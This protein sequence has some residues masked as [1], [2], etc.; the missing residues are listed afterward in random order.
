M[1]IC[2][3]KAIPVGKKVFI[4]GESILESI[5]K[6]KKRYFIIPNSTRIVLNEAYLVDAYKLNAEV[7]EVRK[8]TISRYTG[9]KENAFGSKGREIYEGDIIEGKY[10]CDWFVGVVESAK[11]VDDFSIPELI[12]YLFISN[13]N[14]A[15]TI[16]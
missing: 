8:D 14:K 12:P 13:D 4:Y 9:F 16:P 10:R 6:G 1:K 2:K 7:V 15:K 5:Y 3:Y 11:I